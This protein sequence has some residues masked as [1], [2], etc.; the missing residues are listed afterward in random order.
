MKIPVQAIL[1][2][3][4]PAF[5]TIMVTNLILSFILQAFPGLVRV[6]RGQGSNNAPLLFSPTSLVCIC[7]FQLIVCLIYGGLFL[8]IAVP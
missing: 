1:I 7:G 6:V 5:Q 2:V 4:V 3:N 8:K